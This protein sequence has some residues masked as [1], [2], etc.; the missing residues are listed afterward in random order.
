MPAPTINPQSS[1][2]LLR[3]NQPYSF[4]LSLTATSAAAVS[5]AALDA[6]P[7]GLALNTTNGILSGTPTTAGIRSVRFT[8]INGD[9]TSAAVT[10]AFGILPVPYTAQGT[11]EINLDLD[12]RVV[13]NPQITNGGAPLFGKSNDKNTISLGLIKS[14]IP[15][16]KEVALITVRLKEDDDAL[17]ITISTGDFAKVGSGDNARYTVLLNWEAV[18]LGAMTAGW[19]FPASSGGFVWAEIEVKFL[20]PPPGAGSAILMPLSSR[21]FVCEIQRDF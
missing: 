14:G 7:A 13:W 9:G 19:D 10:V 8:A 20:E 12:T 11:M 4:N 5:W 6:L 21:T 16:D 1:V 3:V 2:P 17:P 15:Q 18:A